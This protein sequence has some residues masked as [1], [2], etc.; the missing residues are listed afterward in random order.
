MLH[1]AMYKLKTKR[2]YST[3]HSQDGITRRNMTV[4][5]LQRLTDAANSL[6]GQSN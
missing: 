2:T 3:E 5:V 4:T 6:W 1:N